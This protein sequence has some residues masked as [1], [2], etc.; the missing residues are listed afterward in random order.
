MG[1]HSREDDEPFDFTSNHVIQIG[2]IPIKFDLFSRKVRTDAHDLRLDY[3]KAV[4]EDWARELGIQTIR[5]LPG[6]SL[7]GA[8]SAEPTDESVSGLFGPISML[9]AHFGVY[10]PVGSKIKV[11]CQHDLR[12]YMQIVSLII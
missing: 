1:S 3:L 9:L 6:R 2:W 11:P 12:E 8:A 4:L 7:V 5:T 10:V